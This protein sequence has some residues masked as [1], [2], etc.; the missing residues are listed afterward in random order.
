MPSQIRATFVC[1]SFS[2]RDEPVDAVFSRCDHHNQVTAT[3]RLSNKCIATKADA[4]HSSVALEDL[5]GFSQRHVVSPEVFFTTG[6]N[7]KSTAIQSD[8]RLK[9]LLQKPARMAN[10]VVFLRGEELV[11]VLFVERAGLEA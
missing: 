2:S 1:L 10:R 8:T 7:S 9:R 3:V 4:S 6:S 11:A 5:L